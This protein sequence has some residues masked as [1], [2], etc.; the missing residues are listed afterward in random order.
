RRRHAGPGREYAAAL[1]VCRPAGGDAMK[2][3]EV[4][5]GWKSI[6]GYRHQVEGRENEDAVVATTDHPLFDAL[7]IVA[8]GV[9]GHDE[10]RLAAETAAAAARDY[11]LRPDLVE[12]YREAGSPSEYLRQALRYANQRVAALGA[13]SGR[14]PGSTLTVAVVADGRLHVAHAGDGSTM[15]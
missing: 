5:L 14:Q 11:L 1:H 10:P 12:R 9:G 4:A 3:S 8:D 13:R 6:P 2:Q 7:M 15:L